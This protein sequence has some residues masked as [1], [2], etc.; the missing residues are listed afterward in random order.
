[1]FNGIHLRPHR[2]L[3][4][5]A[6]EF[7]IIDSISLIDIQISFYSYVSFGKLCLLS[8]W[9]VSSRLSNLWAESYY[10][11]AVHR[12]CNDIPYF[13]FDVSNLCP[14]LFFLVSLDRGLS[15]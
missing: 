2:D 14:L 1:M 13:I 7:I 10:S 3:V 5:S 6:L 9:P 11:F 4:L 15:V 12:I 8:N